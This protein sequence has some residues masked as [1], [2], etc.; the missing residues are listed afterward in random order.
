M[1]SL[2]NGK[3][4]KRSKGER[5]RGSGIFKGGNKGRGGFGAPSSGYLPWGKIIPDFK[6]FPG[7]PGD[8]HRDYREEPEVEPQTVMDN[9]KPCKC[10]KEALEQFKEDLISDPVRYR[11][12]KANSNTA[13]ND[14]LERIGID[15]P[16]P[17]VKTPGWD[18]DLY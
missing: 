11:P 13:V 8:R 6:N 18:R 4:A 15:P 9:D 17:P 16:E 12:F 3:Q 14:A 10:V 7:P 5:G 2:A 1:Q